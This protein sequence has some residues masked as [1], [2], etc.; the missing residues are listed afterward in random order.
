MLH[1]HA[2][3]EATGLRAGQLLGACGARLQVGQNHLGNLAVDA[4]DEGLGGHPRQGAHIVLE[5][6]LLGDDVV[7]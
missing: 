4:L 3:G 7:L 2:G 5:H 1:A 6:G